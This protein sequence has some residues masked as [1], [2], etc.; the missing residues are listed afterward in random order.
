MSMVVKRSFEGRTFA[1]EYVHV[2]SALNNKWTLIANV[3]DLTI[4]ETDTTVKNEYGEVREDVMC[5]YRDAGGNPIMWHL[6]KDPCETHM[7][8]W[9]V[10]DELVEALM[11]AWND[12]HARHKDDKVLGAINFVYDMFGKDFDKIKRA[13]QI[14]YQDDPATK[15]R[16]QI[17]YSLFSHI[18]GASECLTYSR[19][20]L[21]S[22][23]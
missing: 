4:T 6:Q 1:S 15:H 11:Y 3:L 19:E 14:F 5:V 17:V 10:S 23:A 20:F 12:Y 2:F 9:Y 22:Q 21:N 7:K 18:H 8:T 13:Y 16:M